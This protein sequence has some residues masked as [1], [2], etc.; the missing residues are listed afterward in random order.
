MFSRLMSTDVTI[1]G[2][3]VN[4]KDDG[5]ENPAKPKVETLQAAK[6]VEIP[7]QKERTPAA[8]TPVSPLPLRDTAG[9]GQPTKDKCD[10]DDNMEGDD[11]HLM[12]RSTSNE[13]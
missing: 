4:E 6:I 13:N 5:H 11:P 2:C 8:M 3:S 1:D 12:R 9:D 10:D 7:A